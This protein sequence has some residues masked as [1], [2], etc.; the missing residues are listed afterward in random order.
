MTGPRLG[1]LGVG[2]IARAMVEGIASGPRPYDRIVL[3]P[4]GRDNVAALTARFPD[5]EVAGSNADVVAGSDVVVLAVRPE[6]LAEAVAG[7]S[8][9]PDQVLVSALA[10]VPIA[11]LREVLGF[12]GDIVRSIPLPPVSER[13]SV[14]VVYPDHPAGT[15]LFDLLGGTLVPAD[16]EAFA[17]FGGVTATFTAFLDYVRTISAWTTERGVEPADAERFVRSAFA[18]LAPA[19]RDLDRPLDRLVRDHETPGGFNEQLRQHWFDAA[20]QDRL[21]QELDALHER[22]RGE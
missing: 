14:T 7:V 22:A 9:R 20:A 19:L 10:G 6:N 16:E 2:E 4:R 18:G 13:T 1:F 17:M 8:F 3:S 11:R 21:R 12:E 15:T 5:L